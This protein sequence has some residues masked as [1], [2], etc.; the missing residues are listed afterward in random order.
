MKTKAG[1]ILL[2]AGVLA[3]AGIAFLLKPGRSEEKKP[4]QLPPKHTNRLA[5]E[6]SPYLLLHAH[7]PVDWY[8]WGPEAFAK[9][10]KENKLIFLSIG[11]SS[12]YW[13]HVMERESFENEEIAKLL[14]QWFVCIKVDREER[15]DVDSIYMMALQVQGIRGGWP[16]SLFLLPDG[17][18]VGGG[19]YWPPEDRVINGETVRGFKTIIRLVH[20]DWKKQPDVFRTYA[21]RVAEAIRQN[22]VRSRLRLVNAK[23]SRE[24][25]TQV[26]DAVKEEYDPVYGGFGSEKLNFRGPKFPTP[27]MLELV[28]TEYQRSRDAELLEMITNTLDHM[29]RGGIYDQIGGGFHRYSTDRKWVVPHFEKMLYDNAQL[30]SLYSR[31]YG[32]LKRPLYQRVVDQ[33]LAFIAREMTSAEGGF[34]SSLDAETEGEEGKFYVW[35]GAEIDAALSREQ[36]A[37]AKKLFGIEEGPNFEEKANVLVLVKPLPAMA[38]ELG[39]SEKKLIE[40]LDAIRQRLREVRDQRQRPMLDTKVLTSWNGLMI[41]AYADAARTFNRPDWLQTAQRA[42]EFLLSNVRTKE[43]RLR[44]TWSRNAEGVGQAKLN[45]Y[46]E[47]YAYLAHGLLALHKATGDQHWLDEAAD[48]TRTMIA[49]FADKEVGGFFFTSH[50]HEKL[51]VRAKDQYDGAK[52]SS[53]SLAALNLV[54][55]AKLTGDPLFVDHAE[56][57][58]TAFVPSMKANPSAMTTMARALD[59]WLERTRKKDQQPQ[60]KPQ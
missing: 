6:T 18:P 33:T 4:K 35:T 43:G 44:R 16:L 32:V 58:L 26:L 14:N 41:A 51:F 60:R 8:P 1:L 50:D 15:P 5:K 21:E 12:C 37:L 53:N 20:N 54:R 9:A 59:L 49:N 17:R 31:A 7:N 22:I 36:A 11:Y 46:L 3:A 45:A 39:W 28:L 55:L 48:L 42:A 29:A 13:C 2:I 34:Y 30:V 47:D 27:T 10:K 23:P 19:T 38:A 40:R 24:L 25:V 52:P 57:T 56:K